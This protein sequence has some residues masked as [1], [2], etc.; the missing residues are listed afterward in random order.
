MQATF[1]S[2]VALPSLSTSFSRT[3]RSIQFPSVAQRPST[4][5]VKLS[6]K[7]S[8]VQP[9]V[10]VGGGRVGNAL[11][12]LGDGSDT[13]VRRG[14]KIPAG[15][16]GPIFV[17]TRNDVLEGIIDE[18]PPERRE[19]LV[20]L[21]NGM[22]QSFLEKKGLGSNTQALIYFAVAKMGEAPTD[23]VT[24][25]NPEGLTAATGKWA[26]ALATRL[27]KGNLSCHVLG[28]AAFATSMY[29]KLIW[30]SAF[31]LVGARHKCTVGEVESVHKEEVSALIKELCDGVT[32]EKGVTFDAVTVDRLCAYARSVAHFPTAVKEFEWRNGFFYSL[33]QAASEAGRADPFPTHTAWLKEVGAI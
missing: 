1:S 6:V 9:A 3:Q 19:D 4:R 26:D 22:L 17:C 15:T 33:S 16:S 2:H 25:L 8:A 5:V 31:M 12:D 10:I 29:E 20:F 30:I 14:E 32:A 18:C 21:Q 11:F 23:G 24:D 28:E 7:M 13:V 27:Q